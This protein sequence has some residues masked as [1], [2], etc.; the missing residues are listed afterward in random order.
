MRSSPSW[1]R[2]IAFPSWGRRPSVG[3]LAGRAANRAAWLP[4]ACLD[5]LAR[6]AEAR[7]GRDALSA[8]GLCCSPAPVSPYPAISSGGVSGGRSGNDLTPSSR[9]REG[10]VLKIVSPAILHSL[11]W[12]NRLFPGSPEAVRAQASASGPGG[13]RAPGRAPGHPRQRAVSPFRLARRR[14]LVSFKRDPAL[15]GP[16]PGLGGVS[17]VAW[18][19]APGR[20]TVVCA[21][22][23]A[24]GA[25]RAPYA[26][27]ADLFSRRAGSMPDRRSTS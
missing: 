2:T 23:S 18:S 10:R 17:R 7:H 3:R 12:Q 6:P 5:V 13:R 16:R 11:T 24:R 22:T 4:T 25:L 27:L 20:S 19:L 9:A 8:R 21:P 26:D 14:D 15:G 1:K